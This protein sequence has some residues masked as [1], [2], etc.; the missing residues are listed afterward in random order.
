MIITAR[1]RVNLK[2][3]YRNNCDT[4]L[5]RNLHDARL[6]SEIITQSEIDNLRNEN[7]NTTIQTLTN[8]GEIYKIIPPKHKSI[9]CKIRKINKIMTRFKTLKK[10][11][12]NYIT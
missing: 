3:N 8:S 9:N 4:K 10:E 11:K 6:C 12:G 7:V 2:R 5:T 1:I